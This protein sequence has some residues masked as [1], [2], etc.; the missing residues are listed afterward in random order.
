MTAALTRNSRGATAIE[1]AMLIALIA[2]AGAAS[3]RAVGGRVS[4]SFNSSA[5]AADVSGIT[6]NGST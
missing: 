2:V 1:Y 6:Y 4:N 5:T 3:F